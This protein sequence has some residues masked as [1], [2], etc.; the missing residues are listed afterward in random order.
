MTAPTSIDQ[1]QLVLRISGTIANEYDTRQPEHLPLTKLSEG[2]CRLTREEV[3]AVV[4]D[5]VFNSDTKA[6][7]VGPDAMP[8][9]VFNAYRALAKQGK[10]VLEGAKP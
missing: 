3:Q 7:D 4:D 10:R 8:L 9:G 1:S 5:A 2:A 6:V